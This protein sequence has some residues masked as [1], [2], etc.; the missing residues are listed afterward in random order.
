MAGLPRL[1]VR[2][3]RVVSPPR[4]LGQPRVIRGPQVIRGPRALRGPQ[5][6]RPGGGRGRP[7]VREPLARRSR[8]LRGNLQPGAG[9]GAGDFRGRRQAGQPP[10]GHSGLAWCR[11][12][13]AVVAVE[14]RGKLLGLLRRHAEHDPGLSPRLLKRVANVAR[15]CCQ[16]FCAQAVRGTKTI[17]R[18]LQR[19]GSPLCALDQ[20]R[21]THG[22]VLPFQATARSAQLAGPPGAR[23]WSPAVYGDTAY[24]CH[25]ASRGRQPAAV[26][27]GQRACRP[28]LLTSKHGKSDYKKLLDN[29]ELPRFCAAL[30]LRACSG[31]APAL[32]TRVRL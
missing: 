15:H 3:R 27:A 6:I 2:C 17:P 19:A 13:A 23:M 9:R 25:L 22:A 10:V 29:Y 8:G 31:N 7:A 26:T 32:G 24:P 30:A 16:R 12:V 21:I 11:R 1:A 14:Q 28:V 5:V 18:P 20:I 4:A